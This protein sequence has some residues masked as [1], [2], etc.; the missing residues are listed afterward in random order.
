LTN[1]QEITSRIRRIL[2]EA[3]FVNA[4]PITPSSNPWC[5]IPKRGERVGSEVGGLLVI[6]WASGSQVEFFGGSQKSVY[7]DTECTRGRRGGYFIKEAAIE[8][9][10]SGRI[11][12]PEGG[13]YVIQMI[14]LGSTAHG[15]KVDH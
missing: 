10:T 13:W 5:Y 15:S 3:T 4:Q 12:I 9:E 6:L 11:K 1:Q 14:R 7:T 2:P 8:G